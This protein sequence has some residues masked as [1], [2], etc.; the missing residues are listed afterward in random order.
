MTRK[1]KVE[2]TTTDADI[3]ARDAERG[4]T[5]A[6][7]ADVMDNPEWT[8]EQLRTA[9]P[10]AEVFPNL[11]ASIRREASWTPPKQK[12]SLLL[13]AAVIERFKAGARDWQLRIN[14]VLKKAAG[15]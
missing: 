11:A 15:L 12:I 8:D 5:D 6:D 7:L 3:A 2:G 1:S 13:D 9:K 4:Y 10:F 14:E